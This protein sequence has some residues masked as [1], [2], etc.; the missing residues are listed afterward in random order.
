MQHRARNLLMR[1]RTQVINALRAHLAELGPS[2][3]VRTD[4]RSESNND[5]GVALQRDDAMGNLQTL[6]AAKRKT[7]SRRS[8]QIS[9]RGFVRRLQKQRWPSA[10]CAS[11]EDLMPRVRWRKVG[12][13]LEAV[14]GEKTSNPVRV[15]HLLRHAASPAPLRDLLSD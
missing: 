2:A 5:R 14:W 10:S 7:A 4:V 12:E 6:C 9:I 11:R 13:R 1:Q 3:P 15:N 8:L